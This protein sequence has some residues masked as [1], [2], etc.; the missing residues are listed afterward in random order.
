M[1]KFNKYHVTNG[2]IK[3]RVW[4]SLNNRADGKKCVTMYAKDYDDALGMIFGNAYKNDTEILTD[5][6]DK[7]R[8]VLFED[9]PLYKQARAVVEQRKQS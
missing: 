6:F 1:V 8:A 3:A 5:Y 9:H 4:Y 7:G 2:Q